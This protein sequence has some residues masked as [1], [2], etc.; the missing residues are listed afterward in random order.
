MAKAVYS[1]NNIGHYGLGF[2]YYTHFTSPIR[3]YA[4]L[5][6]HRLLFEYSKSGKKINYSPAGLDEISEHISQ[7]ERSAIEAERLSVKLKQIEYLKDHLGNEFNAIISGI[8]HFGIFVKILD[9]LAEGLIR[10]KDLE[11]DFYVY[12][13]K[14]YSLI[15][16]V[17]KKQFRLGDKIRVKLVRVNPDKSEID[18]IILED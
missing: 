13:E 15:G 9:N 4:D 6:V 14:K 17:S 7:C 12:D 3:R 10:L 2:K 11:G 5:M 16:K 18:F 1:V 8:T